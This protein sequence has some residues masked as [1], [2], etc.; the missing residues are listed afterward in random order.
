MIL[1]YEARMAGRVAHASMGLLPIVPILLLPFILIF[2]VVVFP[3]WGIAL[4]VLGSLLLIMRGANALMHLAGSDA[5]ERPARGVYR[6]FRWV[7]TFGGI[8]LRKPALPP[9]DHPL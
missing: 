2:F 9:R 5:L 6:A 8:A 7:L 1:V 3:F 4:A